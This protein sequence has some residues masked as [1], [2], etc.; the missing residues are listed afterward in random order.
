MTK[1]TWTHR[2]A[3]IGICSSLAL[4]AAITVASPVAEAATTA[5]ATTSKASK[6][7]S[8][9]KTFLGTPYKFGAATTTTRNFDCSSLMKRIYGKYGVTLPRTSVAQS[10]MG[11]AVSKANLKVGDLV[12]FSTGS[13]ATGKNVTHVA[14]YI[15]NGKIL[16]TYGQ[17]GVVISDL[18][19]GNWKKTYLKARR[20][21]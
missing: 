8:Y 1:H 21:L 5:T 20:V 9:G 15:G 11:V 6:I 17:P 3:V 4:T 13:R 10:K 18:N 12:F 7:I 2:F 16:H 19:K 14:T